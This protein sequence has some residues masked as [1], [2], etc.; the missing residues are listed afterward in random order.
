AER[1]QGRCREQKVFQGLRR[2]VVKEHVAV[3][4]RCN[5]REWR[6]GGFYPAGG[7]PPP[8][9]W[10]LCRQA[11]VSLQKS[12]APCAAAVDRGARAIQACR[13]PVSSCPSSR[14]KKT[15]ETGARFRRLPGEGGHKINE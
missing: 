2:M 8:A 10:P 1:Q 7:T 3:G 5:E 12:N 14:L 6:S 13:M 11:N 4:A 15:P 9:I